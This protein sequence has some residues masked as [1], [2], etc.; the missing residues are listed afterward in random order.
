MKHSKSKAE[1]EEKALAFF[2]AQNEL[3]RKFDI[4]DDD[5]PYFRIESKNFAFVAPRSGPCP[6]GCTAVVEQLTVNGK[7]VTR[8]TCQC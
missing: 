5:Q 6:P 3:L 1:H 7:K 4:I 2:K 8:I